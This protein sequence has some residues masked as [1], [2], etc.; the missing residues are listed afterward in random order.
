VKLLLDTHTFMWWD[1]QS[2]RLSQTALAA[3]QD[4]ANERVLSVVCVWEMVIKGQLGKLTF[5][6]PIDQL[7]A[8]HVARSVQIL[9]VT[10]DHVLAVENLPVAH[11]DPFDRLLVAQANIEGAALVTADRVFAQYTVQILW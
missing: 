6:L 5:R 4:P 8:E 9:Q 2:A 3:L 1:S 11:K 7:V 10:I